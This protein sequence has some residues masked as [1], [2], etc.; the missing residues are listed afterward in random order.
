MSVQVQRRTFTV[1]EYHRMAEAGILSEDD[2]VELIDG[3]IVKMS[4]IGSCHVACV[5]RL[6]AVLTS[7]IGGAA[8]VSVQN[9]FAVDEYSEPQPDIVIL[10]PSEDFYAHSLPTAQDVLLIIEVADTSLSYDRNVKVPAYA[11]AGV[12][13]AWIADLAGD[14]IEA[15]S[16]PVGGVYRK[17]AWA[18]RG[19][20]LRPKQ[21]PGL[22]LS[23]DDILG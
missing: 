3:E 15:Y 5:N 20:I 18:S 2:R 21:I 16:D 19:Q 11:R 10:K 14:G 13:E 9:P 6:T 4:P 7:K 23:V 22:G 17:V 12:P 1:D 8:I